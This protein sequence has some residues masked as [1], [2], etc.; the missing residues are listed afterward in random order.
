ME[1]ELET[2]QQSNKDEVESLRS[3]NASLR[4]E[5]KTE[6]LHL[7]TEV[8]KERD[9][10]INLEQEV[11]FL[12][13][14]MSRKESRYNQ[15]LRSVAESLEDMKSRKE[16][17]EHELKKFHEIT[18]QSVVELKRK[19]ERQ[20]EGVQGDLVAL[21]HEKFKLEQTY[22]AFQK[23]TA[24]DLAIKC[25]EMSQMEKE[26]TFLKGMLKQTKAEAEKMQLCAIELEREK[27][28]LAGVQ[29]SQRTLREH[30]VKMENEIATRESAL[31]EMTSE[32]ERLKKEDE[33]QRKTASERIK[34]LETQ[35]T[36]LRQE[37]KHLQ[38]SFR[39]QRQENVILRN[40]VEEKASESLE[41]M[42][43]LS[44]TQKEMKQL[45]EKVKDEG[46]ETERCRSQLEI[47]KGSLAE[48]QSVR[49]NLQRR[50]ETVLEQE[51]AKDSRVQSLGWE[52]NR[53][54]KEVECLKEQL[55]IMEE[56]QQL[57]LENLKTAL[58]VSRSETTSLRSDLSEARKTKCAYQTKTFELKDSL[59]TA[60]Q[61]TESLKQELF[62]KRQELNSLLKD[63]LAAR[64]LQLLQE[65]VTKKRE[66]MS[67]FEESQDD[68][69]AAYRVPTSCFR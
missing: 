63:V 59:L 23:K 21:Q 22:D 47:V 16:I 26:V 14:K 51:A 56:R 65:E 34:M 50:L 48:E 55:R 64:N 10:T 11:Q 17:A 15:E 1:G 9:K 39:K 44:C 41:L 25:R 3:L 60:R 27:G 61:I 49:E 42:K 19:Y 36:N 20:L 58:Q 53:R 24:N 30:V 52:L 45:Q 46:N 66:A 7:E 43:K 28:R 8:T 13:D 38:D 33:M 40:E 6:K 68:T 31:L 5:I 69:D 62:V 4:E 18:E 54:A 35:L 12:T 29:A 2:T 67:D 37:S 57:E 32:V